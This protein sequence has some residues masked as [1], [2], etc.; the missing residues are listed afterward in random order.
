M[1]LKIGSL[2]LCLGLKNKRLEI[3]RIRKYNEIKILLCLQEIELKSNYNLD[4]KS[5]LKIISQIQT[6]NH[7]NLKSSLHWPI[8]I[9]FCVFF[10]QWSI[11]SLV[12]T[13]DNILLFLL[14]DQAIFWYIEHSLYHKTWSPKTRVSI[15]LQKCFNR[16][17]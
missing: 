8:L 13:F 16:K 17:L 6:G 12:H 14:W 1:E 11:F 10:E 3:E 15:H 7:P 5:R 4:Y 2:N 9:L